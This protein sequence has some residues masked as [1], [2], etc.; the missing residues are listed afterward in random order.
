MTT[1]RLSLRQPLFTGGF[2]VV[3]IMWIW[4]AVHLVVGG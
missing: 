1:N 2:A 4:F 3:G